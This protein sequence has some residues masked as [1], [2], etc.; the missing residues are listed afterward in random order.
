MPSHW[1]NKSIELLNARSWRRAQ[2]AVLSGV[3][4][5]F[6]FPKFSFSWLVWF[7]LLPM[8]FVLLQPI[9]I[10]AAFVYSL[11]FGTVYEAILLYWVVGVMQRYGFFPLPLA[12]LFYLGFAVF[13][14]LF[15]AVFGTLARKILTQNY[16]FLKRFVPSNLQI[17]ILNSFLVAALWVAVEFWQTRMF[18]GFPWCLLG[19]GIIDYLGIM[20]ISAAT[21][22]YGVSFLVCFINVLLAQALYQRKRTLF[23]ATATLLAILLT[24]DFTF[25]AWLYRSI[26]EMNSDSTFVAP[27][28]HRVAILQ[29]N[30]PQDTDWTRPVLEAWLNTLEQMLLNAKSEIAVMPENP[31]PF[32]YP[33]DPEFLGRLEGMVRKSGSHVIAGVVMTH[34]NEAGAPGVYNSA[35]TLEPDGKLLAEYDKQHL[36]PFGEYVPFRKYLSFAGK[37]TNEISDFTAG[38]DFSLSPINGHRSAIF[39]CYEAIFPNEV[40]EFTRRGAEALINITN[41]GWYG[42]SS[43]PYQHFEMSRVRAIENRRYLIRAANTG[44]SAIIDPYGRVTAKTKLNRQLVAR[45]LFE[46]RID[47]TFYVRFGDVFAWTCVVLSLGFVVFVLARK[48]EE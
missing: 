3:L 24:G 19:Y 29:M 31:A 47:R 16:L 23:I 40:R 9:T 34:P 39:I 14:A 45:G 13:I 48:K 33:D 12:L 21:G 4:L 18:G 37:L 5:G 6:V 32:D 2:L 20:Q 10:R 42:N 30:I 26:P 7:A 17:A 41:D 8:I 35:A 38:T 27:S 43:A 11:L 22:I 25:Q 36:V 44:I 28:A 46:Y 15:L 1:F